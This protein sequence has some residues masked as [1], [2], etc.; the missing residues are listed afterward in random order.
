MSKSS[1]KARD[2][3]LRRPAS[4][5]VKVTIL[6]TVILDISPALLP[7]III[8]LIRG[9]IFGNLRGWYS[10]PEWSFASIVLYGLAISR[11]IELKMGAQRDSSYRLEAGSRLLVLLMVLAVITLSL[12]ILSSQGVRVEAKLLG[13][14]QLA[15]VVIAILM[16][17]LAEWFIQDRHFRFRRRPWTMSRRE[18]YGDIVAL[19]KSTSE[20]L[21][22]LQFILSTANQLPRAS[23]QDFIGSRSWTEDMRRSSYRELQRVEGLARSIRAKYLRDLRKR[24]ALSSEAPPPQK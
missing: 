15:L 3:V 22:N 16:L 14:F 21:E 10:W 12:A 11:I 8:T 23:M 13:V 17:A 1:P 4:Q 24:G 7:I 9:M 18:Y 5:P 19:L 6:R 2:G 20:D